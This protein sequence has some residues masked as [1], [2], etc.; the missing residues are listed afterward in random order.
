MRYGDKIIGLGG[1]DKKFD[2]TIIGFGSYILR[3]KYMGKKARIMINKRYTG[4]YNY[5]AY[6]NN[7]L[8]GEDYDLEFSNITKLLDSKKGRKILFGK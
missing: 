2:I 8:V 6:L 5:K 3:G 7:K 1:V 4:D